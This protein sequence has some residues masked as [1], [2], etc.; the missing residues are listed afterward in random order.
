MN[1]N[2][3]NK[4]LYL[5]AIQGHS[6]ESAIDP[7]L[8]DNLLIPKGFT[9]NLYHVGNANELNSMTR[10]GSTPGGTSLKRGRQAV[11]FTTVNPTEDAHG[12]QETPRGL[13]KPRIAPYKNTWKRFQNTVCWCNLK[14]SQER[15]LHFY[16]TRSHAVLLC[17]TLPAARIEKAV[18]MKTTDELYQKV[19]LTPRVPRVVLKSNSQY[20]LQ[21]PQNQDA[22]SSWAPSSDSKSYG[23]TCNNTVDHKVAAVPLSAVEQQNTTRENKVKRLI[24]KFENHKHKD[25]FIQNLRQTEKINKCSKELQ[26]LIADMNNNR[27]LRTFRKI[28]QTATS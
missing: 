11:F 16:Q 10:N 23:D 2:S 28:F 4:V 19:L 24:E 18:C 13:T 14:P 22:R 27:D 26:D 25:S 5:R 7:E 20:G 15:G 6:G 3:S 9:E 12:M 8:Q 17:N 21:D 1:P